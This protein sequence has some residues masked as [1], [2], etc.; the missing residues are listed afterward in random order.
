VKFFLGTLRRRKG[1]GGIA[2]LF[3]TLA[4]DE[5]SCQRDVQASLP[6]RKVPALAV[7]LEGVF[8]SDKVW[9]MASTQPNRAELRGGSAGQLPRAPTQNGR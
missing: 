8:S 1:S 2:P 6:F 3:L 9:K 7:K 4:F 5:V